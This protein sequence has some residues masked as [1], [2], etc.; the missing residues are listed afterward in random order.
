MFLPLLIL[1][2]CL[3]GLWKGADLVVSSASKIAKQLGMSDLVIGLTVVAFATS[4]PEFAVTVTA[5][6]AGKSD[7]SV[8]NV[9]GSNIFNLFFILGLVALVGTVRTSKKM[10]Y[11]DGSIL[12]GTSILLMVFMYDKVLTFYEGIIFLV[13]LTGYVIYLLVDKDKDAEYFEEG[14]FKW[15]HILQFVAG[16]AVIIVS[17]HYFVESASDIARILGVSEWAIGV[18]IVAAGTSAPEMATSLVAVIKGRHG[19]SAGNL[20][21]S[22]VFNL[23]GVLG[24]ASVIKPLEII[25]AAYNSIVLLALALFVVV[26]FMRTGWKISRFEGIILLIIVAVRWYFDFTN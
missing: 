15:Y 18:T 11:R 3:I 20:I 5:A 14:N 10:V 1:I 17:G 8:G 13:I 16:T 22:D 9:V 21:G 4:A 6:I 23:L 7:I 26:I 2:A 24:V 12:V 19:M 25:P